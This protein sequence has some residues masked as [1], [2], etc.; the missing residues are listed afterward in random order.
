MND[1]T[2]PETG[3]RH[4]RDLIRQ[5]EIEILKFFGG[6]K[7]ACASLQEISS[8]CLLAVSRTRLE[9]VKLAL[10]HLIECGALRTFGTGDSTVYIPADHALIKRLVDDI[11]KLDKESHPTQ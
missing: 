8:I 2:N 1:T 11:E 9:Q 7:D 4:D 3:D 6:Q 5:L 10:S